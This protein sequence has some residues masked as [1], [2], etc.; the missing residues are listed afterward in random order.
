MPDNKSAERIDWQIEVGLRRYDETRA[1]NCLS[2]P[3]PHG[4]LVGVELKQNNPVSTKENK[5]RM[6]ECWSLCSPAAK[7][8]VPW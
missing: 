7:R 8:C 3:T 4:Q 6:G 2:S 1:S 5:E